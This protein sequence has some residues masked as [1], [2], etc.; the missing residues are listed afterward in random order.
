MPEGGGDATKR[1]SKDIVVMHIQNRKGGGDR[2]ASKKGRWF[3]GAGRVCTKQECGF[4]WG[5]HRV[6]QRGGGKIL[7]KK[8]S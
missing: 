5:F 4:A 6:M 7:H 2:N 1:K 8:E 3:S